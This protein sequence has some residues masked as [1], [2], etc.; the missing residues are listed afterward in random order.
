M[1]TLAIYQIRKESLMAICQSQKLSRTEVIQQA[2]T[3][4]LEIKTLK[5]MRLAFGKTK[6]L[7][8]FFIRNGCALKGK[9]CF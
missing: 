9:R 1:R 7:M 6:K 8:V 4:Y 3:E 2:I 5:M